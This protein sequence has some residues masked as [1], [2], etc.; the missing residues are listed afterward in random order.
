MSS[1][2]SCA[3]RCTARSALFAPQQPLRATQPILLDYYLYRA[4]KDAHYPIENV[5]L[6]NLPGVVHYLHTEIVPGSCMDDKWSLGIMRK[7]QI[8][9]VLR[10]RIRS[11]ISHGLRQPPGEV[12]QFGRWQAMDYGVAKGSGDYQSVGC[13]KISSRYP[14]AI[15]YSLPGRC[16]SK[17]F[18]DK[19]DS[20][21]QQ[22]P[23]GE[24]PKGV[25]PDGIRCMWSAEVTGFVMVDDLSGISTHGYAD[26]AAF[27]KADGKEIRGSDICFWHGD[28]RQHMEERVTTLE[29]LFLAKYPSQGRDRPP[30][31]C[32]FG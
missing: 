18:W 21:R 14:G 20:C 16:H 11:M 4:Q 10:V 24:C 32:P 6:A 29:S 28:D 5:N 7:F 1:I 17:P 23:G 31:D 13:K 25:V 8:D 9:R 26:H 2:D 30:P 12:H 27:C 3:D 19:S 15:Y 22:E